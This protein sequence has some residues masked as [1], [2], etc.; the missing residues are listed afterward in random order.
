MGLFSRSTKKSKEDESMAELATPAPK[1][2]RWVSY[3]GKYRIWL[4]E[5]WRVG[6]GEEQPA[7]HRAKNPTG[8]VR[9]TVYNDFPEDP[10]TKIRENEKELRVN[11]DADSIDVKEIDGELQL[12]WHEVIADP[13]QKDKTSLY[14]WV[15]S[16][17]NNLLLM[18]FTSDSRHDGS[19][20][21][22]TE[23][24]EV[25]EIATKIEVVV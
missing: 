16:K 18:S 23:L 19:P 17:K 22:Q 8:A 6:F 21:V 10:K 15:K 25:R 11:K 5:G 9:V 3:G 14:G 13:G 2:G 7:W 20:D 24:A 4:P 1:G 12:S